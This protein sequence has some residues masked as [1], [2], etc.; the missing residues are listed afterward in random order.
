MAE[1]GVM[2][3]SLLHE[4]RQ[5]LYTMK[6]LAELVLVNQ[7]EGERD[8]QRLRRLL[9][10]AEHM[11]Q[12]IGHYGAMGRDDDAVVLVDLNRLV[13]DSV[14]MLAHRARELRATVTFRPHSTPLPIRAR[15]TAI[16]QI[17]V[18]LMQNALDAVEEV[19]RREV[20]V[21]TE[22][23]GDQARW[24]VEDSGGG[25]PEALRDQLF[26]PFVTTKPP[27]RGTGLGLYITRRL[28]RAAGGGMRLQS[29][30]VGARAVIKLPCVDV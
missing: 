16:R 4:L 27:G 23:V 19:D 1:M 10:A 29:D 21:C 8:Q 17:G 9:E 22:L 5:P 2:T 13:A 3:S 20:V 24:V 30:G 26:E 14:Q 12:L 6:T 15:E 11:D 25:I 18:N 7:T 28:V